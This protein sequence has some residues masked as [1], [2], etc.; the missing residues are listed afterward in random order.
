MKFSFVKYK[1]ASFALSLI[2]I[3]AGLISI[4]VQGF[5]LGIDFTGG[6]MLDLKFAKPVTVSEVRDVLQNYGLENSTLQLAGTE[7]VDKAPNVIIRTRVLDETERKAAHINS[8][9]RTIE[10]DNPDAF[11]EPA[12]EPVD[13]TTPQE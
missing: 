1:Y 7:K 4:A 6:T 2:V 10:R 3:A 9:L 8:L 12:P 11:A 5:N 13:E